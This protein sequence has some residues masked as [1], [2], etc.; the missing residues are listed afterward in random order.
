MYVPKANDALKRESL[1]D[2][3]TM[4]LE[5]L[6][7]FSDGWMNEITRSDSILSRLGGNFKVLSSSHGTEFNSNI[8][9]AIRETGE[10]MK[11][12]CRIKKSTELT[13][14]EQVQSACL[15]CLPASHK[16]CHYS[17]CLLVLTSPIILRLGW[18][19]ESMITTGTKYE[20]GLLESQSKVQIALFLDVSVSF[21]L[22]EGNGLIVVVNM[23]L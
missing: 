2:I 1:E 23:L 12:H 8:Y 11:A 18:S 17:G 15:A 19:A 7:R 13:A 21:S 5:W 10:I 9:S 3:V 4:S 20:L 22:F 16:F 6:S 14:R